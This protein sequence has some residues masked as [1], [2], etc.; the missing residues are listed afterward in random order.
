M[1]KITEEKQ[2][3]GK[4]KDEIPRLTLRSTLIT[5]FPGETEKDF[6]ELSDFVSEGWFDHLGVFE[7]RSLDG[8]RS[9]GLPGAVDAGTARERKKEIMTRQKKVV[10]MRYASMK[11]RTVEVLVESAKGENAAAGRA[12]FQ[13]PEIDG[14]MIIDGSC[15]KGSFVKVKITGYKGYDLKGELVS[16]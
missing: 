15:V 14:G 1:V 12:I 13:A 16:K 11:G 8:T 4:S 7:Y 10:A 6:R 9:S 3:S 5:G 2:S